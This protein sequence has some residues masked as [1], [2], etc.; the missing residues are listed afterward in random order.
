MTDP[1][2]AS[3]APAIRKKVE[4]DEDRELTEEERSQER[5]MLRRIKAA[6]RKGSLQ[7][8]AWLEERGI[9]LG[10]TK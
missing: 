5:E 10:D 1:F 3:E 9:H 4:W 6:A 8:R 7:A 2:E